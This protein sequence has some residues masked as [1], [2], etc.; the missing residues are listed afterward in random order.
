MFI[1]TK[2]VMK[3]ICKVF[4]SEL[5]LETQKVHFEQKNPNDQLT[6]KEVT[7]AYRKLMDRGSVPNINKTP[8]FCDH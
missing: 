7:I 4:L 1:E 6:P 2:D 3:A 5:V 8:F